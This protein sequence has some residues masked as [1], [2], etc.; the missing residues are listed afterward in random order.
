MA[1][2]VLGRLRD[3]LD[4]WPGHGGVQV[5]KF[6][7]PTPGGLVNI[8]KLIGLIQT[9]ILLLIIM[10]IFVYLSVYRSYAR[11]YRSGAQLVGGLL[12]LGQQLRSPWRLRQ[13]PADSARR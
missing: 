8:V 4:G 13:S 12:R 2:S 10:S 3:T 6:G 11:M 7:G 1:E 5:G 9:A